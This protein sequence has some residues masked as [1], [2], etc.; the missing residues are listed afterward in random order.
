[1]QNGLPLINLRVVLVV[2]SSRCGNILV[3]YYYTAYNAPLIR[4]K[5]VFIYLLIDWLL[6]N[7]SYTV[8]WEMRMASD[9]IKNLL[10]VGIPIYYF[11]VPGLTR[12]NSR[13]VYKLNKNRSWCL[14]LL[15]TVMF[16]VQYGRIDN[17]LGIVDVKVKVVGWNFLPFW[18][19]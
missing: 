8:V 15:L 11:L 7:P 6:V 9:F 14:I 4:Y 2:R 1:M 10:Y 18:L 12:C 13:K 3:M 19:L 16:V 5:W 17:Q